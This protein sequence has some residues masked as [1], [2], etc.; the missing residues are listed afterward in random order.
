MPNAL[1]TL[2]MLVLEVLSLSMST[3]LR[4]YVTH[5]SRLT[6]ANQKQSRLT[7][8]R[9]LHS[10]LP[11]STV[12]HRVGAAPLSIPRKARRFVIK[13]YQIST[14]NMNHTALVFHEFKAHHDPRRAPSPFWFRRTSDPRTAKSLGWWGCSNVYARHTCMLPYINTASKQ[15]GI[16]QWIRRL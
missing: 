3:S 6:L 12:P 5:K 2:K 7:V 10:I 4:L 1:G 8:S 9:R 15:N 14:K 11:P 16:E 13:T